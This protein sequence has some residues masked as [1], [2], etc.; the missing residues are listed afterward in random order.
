MT[1]AVRTARASASDVD[2]CTAL[3]TNNNNTANWSSRVS[4]YS[5]FYS[6]IFL[7][8]NLHADHY[9]KLV[10]ICISIVLY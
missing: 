4:S 8:Q 9:H 1:E 3:I 6:M 10:L 2:S 7:S 5:N